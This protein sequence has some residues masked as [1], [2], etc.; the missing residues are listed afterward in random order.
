MDMTD[1]FLLG[2][3]L[4]ALAAFPIA[5]FLYLRTAYQKGGWTEV[6][7]A[8]IVAGVTLLIWAGISLW[9]EF[10]IRH[11]LR[12]IQHPF[13]L[14][15]IFFLVLVGLAHCALKAWIENHDIH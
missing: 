5:V 7:G 4:L 13:A 10:E 14:G 11:I 1:K 3:L 2:L 8:A 12:A 9:P 6:K 15:S